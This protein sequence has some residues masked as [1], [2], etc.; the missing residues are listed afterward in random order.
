MLHTIKVA[1]LTTSVL[2]LAYLGFS[3]L[4]FNETRQ[5]ELA[6][7]NF[8][9]HDLSSAFHTLKRLEKR[10]IPT[11]PLYLSYLYRS[12]KAFEA[13]SHALTSLLTAPLNSQQIEEVKIGLAWNH[14]LN[15]EYDSIPPI[16]LENDSPSRT[17]TYS[18]L[19]LGLMYYD[20]HQYAEA[21]QYLRFYLEN[22]ESN[23]W[24]YT[25][26][27]QFVSP[28]TILIKKLATEIETN[29][30]LQARAELKQLEKSVSNT[31]RSL[32]IYLI[33]LSYLYEAKDMP[34]EIA[35]NYH[36]I[37]SDYLSQIS[38]NQ[39]AWYY[40]KQ[41]MEPYLT[42]MLT[43]SH[44]LSIP[45][46]IQW[47]DFVNNT[48]ITVP[49][50][51]DLLQNIFNRSRFDSAELESF[52]RLITKLESCVTKEEL[53]Q[54]LQTLSRQVYASNDAKAF[55]TLVNIYEHLAD[56][57]QILINQYYEQL[58]T[59]IQE[60]TSPSKEIISSICELVSRYEGA[61][62]RRLQLAKTLVDH[63]LNTYLDTEQLSETLDLIALSESL[64]FVNEKSSWYHY[65][66]NQMKQHSLEN[67]QLLTK[68]E[69]SY[70]FMRK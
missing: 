54:H 22:K 45:L 52:H 41:R 7:E 63:S 11:A 55:K 47:V 65:L 62:E 28:E 23:K 24:L 66:E 19:I 17:N 30:F 50:S 31:D 33:G 49:L 40:E 57:Q 37:A 3:Y 64:V 56:H 46:M 67:S 38:W 26:I 5:V 68:L 61:S 48:G 21:R 16:L 32:V 12:E 36:L 18:A 10:G 9:N 69:E 14:Y 43:S 60:Y 58:Y 13:S 59:H 39:D 6:Y 70:Q 2:I 53:L 44:D 29:D 20:K 51:F 42:Q 8:V 25:A 4:Y 15:K 1:L 27:H 34:P 35:M